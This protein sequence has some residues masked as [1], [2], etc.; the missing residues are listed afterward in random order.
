M[1]K[2]LIFLFDSKYR[3]PKTPLMAPRI[4]F[5]NTWNKSTFLLSSSSAFV[6]LNPFDQV[7]PGGDISYSGLVLNSDTDSL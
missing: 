3:S 6:Y 1:C 5:S 2:I 7:V 4:P